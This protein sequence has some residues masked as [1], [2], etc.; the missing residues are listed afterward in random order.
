MFKKLV[1]AFVEFEDTPEGAKQVKPTV[2][3]SS[4]SPPTI[5]QA[6][7]VLPSTAAYQTHDADMYEVLKKTVQSRQTAYTAL[8]LTSES[9][10]QVIP[11]ETQRIKAAFVTS[12][13][14]RP[15]ADVLKAIDVHLSDLEGDRTRFGHQLAAQT[16]EKVDGP[17]RQAEAQR[18]RISGINDHITQLKNEIA[19]LENQITDTHTLVSNLEAQASA[20]ELEITQVGERFNKTVEFAKSELID[21]KA[22]LSTVLS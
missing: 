18:G 12:S 6:G 4:T 22:Q 20:A 1:G 11:D 5:G 8:L 3:P 2:A 19:N 16:T 17:R 10:R 21:R 14:G 9:L 13:N 15:P 7:M